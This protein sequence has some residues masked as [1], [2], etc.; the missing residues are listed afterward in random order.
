MLPDK[1][2]SPPGQFTFPTRPS[3]TSIQNLFTDNFMKCKKK[4]KVREEHASPFPSYC[5]NKKAHINLKIC[6]RKV[7][8]ITV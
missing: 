3:N 7:V 8:S 4:R 1:H 5:G 6:S 2:T